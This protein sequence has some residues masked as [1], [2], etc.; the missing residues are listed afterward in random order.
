MKKILAVS[1]SGGH[2]TQLQRVSSAFSE[3]EVVFV[4]TLKGYEKYVSEHKFYKVQDASSWSKINLLVLFFEMVVIVF[5]EKPDVVFTTG[6]APGLFGII[7]GRFFGSKTIWLDSIANYEQLSL[8]GRLASYFANLHLTQWSHLTNK[9]T[10][11]LG[12]VI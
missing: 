9:K 1:S 4:S 7:L 11:C 5:K 10:K 8:S 6:A 2:W 12:K 3:N